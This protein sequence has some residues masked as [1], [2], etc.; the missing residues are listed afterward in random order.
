MIQTSARLLEL[1]TL[2]QQRREWT[3]P[4]LAERLGVGPRTIRRDVQKLRELGYP[5]DA[6][7]GVAG[8]Y[9][10]GAGTKV[11]PLLLDDAEAVAVAVGLRS[12]AT[13]SIA[14][15]EE[16]SFRALSKLEQILPERLRDRVRDLGSATSAFGP[17]GPRIDPDLL[18]SIAAACR[19]AARL[20][21]TYESRVGEVTEREVEPNAMVHGGRYWYLVA[22]DLGREGWRSFRIDR[23]GSEIEV[24]AASARREVPGGDAAAFVEAGIHG[25]EGG[26]DAVRGSVR[27]S[28]P[29]AEIEKRIPSRY[30]TVEP[31]GPDSCLVESA[32]GWSSEFLVWM[33]LM[34]VEMTVLGPPEMAGEAE[35]IVRRL[36]GAKHEPP[37]WTGDAI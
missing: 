27:L 13:G 3:G 34:D 8:G 20:R 37:K 23:I 26:P 2:L 31:D 10:L 22:Y 1:L 7:P 11:P 21:F 19:D 35:A 5:I 24:G 18:A 12:A 9:R 15:I 14:G 30:A 36:T 28:A 29:A 6:A 17:D 16:T 25:R 4:D 32:A 33:A